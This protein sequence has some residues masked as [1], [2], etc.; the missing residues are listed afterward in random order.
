MANLSD[1]FKLSGGFGVDFQKINNMFGRLAAAEP[2]FRRHPELL[3]E[4][5]RRAGSP[6]RARYAIG[7]VDEAEEEFGA[8]RQSK[9]LEGCEKGIVVASDRHRHMDVGNR[10]LHGLRKRICKAHHTLAV[11]WFDKMLGLPIAVTEM[12]AELHA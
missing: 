2:T 3:D 12:E 5:L 1:G 4:F 9:I 6:H 11:L 7:A 8:F 10:M